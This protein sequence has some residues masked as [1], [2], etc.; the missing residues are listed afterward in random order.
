MTGPELERNTA[1]FTTLS[2][3]LWRL[4]EVLD[5]LLFKVFET[6][7]VMRSGQPKWL[8]KASRELDSALQEVRHV[9]VLRAVETVSIADQLGLPPDVSLRAVAEGAPSPWDEI[10]REH[11]EALRKLSEEIQSTTAEVRKGTAAPEQQ[12]ADDEDFDVVR[13]FL[14]DT[15]AKAAQTS[16]TSF[17]S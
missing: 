5:Q 4:R 17:L 7:L 1:V 14:T 15:L 8:A 6:Q 13:R 3:T 2:S 12:T 16:L 9:E 10:F 11:R